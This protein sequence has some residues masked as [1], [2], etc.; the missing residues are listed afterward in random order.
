MTSTANAQTAQQIAEHSAKIH[1]DELVAALA[2]E[3]G[4]DAF[5]VIVALRPLMAP[6]L[7]THLA[8]QWEICPEHMTHEDICADDEL[9]CEAGQR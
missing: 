9:G 1:L 8:D 5:E 2:D 6:T 3:D 7:W 4:P